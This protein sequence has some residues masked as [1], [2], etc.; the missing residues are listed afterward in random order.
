MI[1]DFVASP[2]R[3]TMGAHYLSQKIPRFFLL[4]KQREGIIKK[5]D[6]LLASA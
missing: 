3:D 2:K 4:G 5:L 6:A 1:R